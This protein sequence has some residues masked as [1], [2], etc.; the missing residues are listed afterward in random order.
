MIR[1]PTSRSYAPHLRVMS[2][3]RAS[4]RIRVVVI[5]IDLTVPLRDSVL[6]AVASR[7]IDCHVLTKVGFASEHV[8]IERRV[9]VCVVALIRPL[10]S[11]I[12]QVAVPFL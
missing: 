9:S 1:L 12:R 6:H 5:V 10:L 7:V 4:A 2:T 3:G 11:N 8:R